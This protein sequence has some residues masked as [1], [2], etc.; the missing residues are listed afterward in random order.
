M[1]QCFQTYWERSANSVCVENILIPSCNERNLCLQ[2]CPIWYTLSSRFCSSM[3]VW[4]SGSLKKRSW[5]PLKSFWMHLFF[6]LW[7][8]WYSFVNGVFPYLWPWGRPFL[9]TYSWKLTESP[10]YIRWRHGWHHFLSRDARMCNRRR[11]YSF[12]IGILCPAS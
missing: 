6:K 4:N 11:L 2:D 8:G 5:I 7:D 10:M 1:V 9:I 3:D 12:M